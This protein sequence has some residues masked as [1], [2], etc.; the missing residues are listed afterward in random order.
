M[1]PEYVFEPEDADVVIEAL[2]RVLKNPAEVRRLRA[3]KQFEDDGPLKGADDA[4]Y[5]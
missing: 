3:I 1:K 2:L 4:K 5:H